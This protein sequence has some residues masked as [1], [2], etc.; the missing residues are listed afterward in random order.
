[1]KASSE[2]RS[3]VNTATNCA[4]NLAGHARPH[5]VHV[6][7]SEPLRRGDDPRQLDRSEGLRAQRDTAKGR[8]ITHTVQRT[9]TDTDLTNLRLK[10][11]QRDNS[12]TEA[13][14]NLAAKT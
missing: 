13:H 3:S 11:V 12:F 8:R 2:E 14:R 5:T 10:C 1:V 9:R 7:P 6:S 4:R